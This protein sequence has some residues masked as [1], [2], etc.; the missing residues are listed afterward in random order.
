M[1]AKEIQ[2]ETPPRDDAALAEIARAA[3]PGNLM[4]AARRAGTKTLWV[5]SGWEVSI[6]R[7]VLV[8]F[9]G[10]QKT[11]TFAD[12]LGSGPSFDLPTEVEAE[13]RDAVRACVHAL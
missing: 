4:D 11:Q 13:V 7:Y 9:D 8:Y 12:F 10:S 1:F 3:S 6:V 2:P 5:G